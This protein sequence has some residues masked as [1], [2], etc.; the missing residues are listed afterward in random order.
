MTFVGPVPKP[1]FVVVVRI[2]MDPVTPPVKNF[3]LV[4]RVVL[5][6]I[7]DQVVVETIPVRGYCIMNHNTVL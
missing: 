6:A 2:D 3:H 7:N 4:F 5:N 1:G